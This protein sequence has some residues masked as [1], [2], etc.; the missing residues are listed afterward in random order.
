MRVCCYINGF[1]YKNTEKYD[2]NK[3]VVVQSH[4]MFTCVKIN[5]ILACNCNCSKANDTGCKVVLV[6]KQLHHN[7]RFLTLV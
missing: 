4:P 2:L 1:Y 5:R 3:E 6:I 7:I